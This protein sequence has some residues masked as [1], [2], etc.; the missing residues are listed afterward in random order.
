MKKLILIVFC[1]APLISQ[2]WDRRSDTTVYVAFSGGLSF[3]SLRNFTIDQNHIAPGFG[4]YAEYQPTREFSIR[5]GFG[6]AQYGYR[7]EGQ[8]SDILGNPFDTT[9]TTALNYFT[10]PISANLNLGRKF[11]PYLGVGIEAAFL[12]SARQYARLPETRNGIAV[13]PYNINRYD[14]GTYKKTGFSV[15][16]QG[17]LEYRIKPNICLYAEYRYLAGM[18]KVFAQETIYG[19]KLKINSWSV[20]LGIKWGIP[21][22]YKVYSLN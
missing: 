20:N 22:T 4:L 2:A 5:A 10:I 17:G 8:C 15:F 6:L 16:A 14:D 18:T 12:I 13:D 3:S 7:F 1:L 11:N 21:I 9:I 19:D